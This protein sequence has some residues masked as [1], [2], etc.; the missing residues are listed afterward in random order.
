MK[1]A[2]AVGNASAHKEQL[3]R[4]MGMSNA[5][6][7]SIGS[8]GSLSNS[9]SIAGVFLTQGAPSLTLQAIVQEIRSSVAASFGWHTKA[10]AKLE[11]MTSLQENWNGSGSAPPNAEVLES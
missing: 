7:V 10:M 8:G 4:S 3:S 11:G 6:E 2:Y 5:A 9:R 1:L